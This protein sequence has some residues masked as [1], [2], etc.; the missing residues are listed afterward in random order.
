MTESPLGSGNRSPAS[1]PVFDLGVA[2]YE[3]LQALQGRLRQAVADGLVAGVLLLLEHEPVITLGSRGTDG[4][5]RLSAGRGRNASGDAAR[6]LWGR[7]TSIP[8]VRSER[9]GQAT[10]HAPGQL[11]SYPVVPVPDHDLGKYVR[12]LEECLIVVLREHGIHA[13]RRPRHPGLYVSGD[14]IASVGLRCQKWVASHG[15][16]LNVTVD[17]TL[18][19]SIVSCG[20]ATLRQTSMESLLGERFSMAGVKDAYCRAFADVFGWR[21]APTRRVVFSEVEKELG[22]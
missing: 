16:S 22:L 12:G 11:V 20:E 4:D 7:L 6:E 5:L 2:P 19:D 14:K 3:P 13:D 21:V 15:T 18:F 8:V 17:L 10:L 1:L 9:G